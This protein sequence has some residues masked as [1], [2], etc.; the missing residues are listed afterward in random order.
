MTDPYKRIRRAN[1]RQQFDR[2]QWAEPVQFVIS[3]DFTGTGA[4]TVDITFNFP[5]EGPPLFSWGVEL[6]E[7]EVLT[8][9]DYP[10]VTSGVAVWTTEEV[11]ENSAGALLYLGATVWYR[12]VSTRLYNTRLRTAFEGIAYKNPEHF[13]EIGS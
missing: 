13:V 7:D 5:F 2:V 6:Q 4:A 8:E 9:G 3:T 12:S 11:S 1:V 10:H